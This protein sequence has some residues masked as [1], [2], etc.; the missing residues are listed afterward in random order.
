VQ[1]EPPTPSPFAPDV[2]AVR[3]WLEEMIAA[4]SF[5]KLI[6]TILG[7][8]TRMRDINTELMKR[9]A[10]LSR[11]RPR[12]EKLKGLKGQLLLP[13]LGL[14]TTPSN[15]APSTTSPPETKKPKKS[16]RGLHPGRG[17][18]PAHLER[19]PVVTSVP[20][21]KRTCPGCGCEMPTM[22]YAEHE[23]LELIPARFVV[24][25]HKLERCACVH[26]DHIV[27]A[28]APPELVPGGKLGRTLIVEALCDKYVEHQ[29]IERQCLRFER[30]GVAIASQ[31][32]GRS[33]AVAIDK[34][35]PLAKLIEEQTRGPGLLGN[36]ATSIPVLDRDAPDGI[37]MGTM[38]AWTNARW[39][40]FFYSASGDSDSVRTFLGE[41]L[42]RTVQCDGTNVMTFLERAGGKRPGCWAHGRRR[43]VE[44]ARGG[45]LLALEGVRLIQPLF[46]IEKRSAAAGDTAEQRK[47]RRLDE[48]TPVLAELRAWLDDKRGVIPPKTPMGAALGYLHRQW[49]RLV[50]F[51]EDGNIELTNNRRERELRKLVLGRRNWLFTWKDL[52]GE[53]TAHILSIVATAIAHDLNPRAYLHVVTRLLVEG[54]PA[55]RLRELLPDRIGAQHPEL[56]VERALSS[57]AMPLLSA[58]T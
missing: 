38:W 5:A 46:A 23:T 41:D 19:V 34:L 33:V 9:V 27:S 45:D 40:A 26:D 1:N 14:V 20:A 7:L 37:R 17:A 51:L 4:L 3:A 29:P 11:K 47:A 24:L 13:L 50:L 2:V 42:C 31:T 10:Y 15:T 18:L 54:W 53:R 28:T 30:A 22:G 6:A 35:A 39:V 12:S 56:V 58:A 21:A 8:I 36:D 49:K 25:L 43:F 48:S 55:E 16:R 57:D 52:G 44:A 32:L